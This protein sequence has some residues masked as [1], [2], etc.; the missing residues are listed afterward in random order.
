METWTDADFQEALDER[1]AIVQYDGNLPESVAIAE[2]L[3]WLRRFKDGREGR[4]ARM[5]GK[6]L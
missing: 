3:E 6:P 4:T 5:E 2:G 1:I